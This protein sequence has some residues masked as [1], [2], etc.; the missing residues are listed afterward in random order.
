MSFPKKM[1]LPH[2]SR[3]RAVRPRRA[4]VMTGT[5]RRDRELMS[6]SIA[7]GPAVAAFLDAI[8]VTREANRTGLLTSSTDNAPTKLA[9]FPL[10]AAADPDRIVN[11][12]RAI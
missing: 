8:A 1:L 7:A 9:I 12:I 5:T 11:D 6:V 2:P 10:T 4:N 3:G